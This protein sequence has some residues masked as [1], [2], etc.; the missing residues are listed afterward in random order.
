[1][2]WRHLFVDPYPLLDDDDPYESPV[3]PE[4][5][6]VVG[7]VAD[8]T[9][10]IESFGLRPIISRKKVTSPYTAT[11]WKRLGKVIEAS[12]VRL[13]MTRTVFAYSIG[14]SNKSIA[15]IE[16]GRVFA[17]PVVAPA[18]DYNSD[19][20]VLR[21]AAFI[22]MTLEWEAGA[23]TAILAD[24]GRIAEPGAPVKVR[25]HEDIRRKAECREIGVD[26][27]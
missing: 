11:D 25:T 20:Y 2:E 13:G 15:R 19:V 23:V 14:S 17:D 16:S 27:R 10:Y 6:S 18:G 22:E 12:R 24:P 8:M 5:N 4:K 1:M 21:R 7:S 3:A 9:A 26:Y